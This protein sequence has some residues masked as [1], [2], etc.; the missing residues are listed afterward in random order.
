[1]ANAA[2]RKSWSVYVNGTEVLTS[3]SFDVAMRRVD[4]LRDAAG[5]VTVEYGGRELN[6]SQLDD[7][8]VCCIR[9]TY[10]LTTFSEPTETQ[11]A[12]ILGAEAI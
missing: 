5:P 4:A 7:L 11:M 9:P 10:P 1:M 12:S 3:E 8:A 6:R 2:S